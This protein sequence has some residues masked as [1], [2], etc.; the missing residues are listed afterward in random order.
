MVSIGEEIYLLAT[1]AAKHLNVSRSTFYIRYQHLLNRV[2]IGEGG[3]FYYAV[4]DLNK[5][6]TIKRFQ[7]KV[8]SLPIAS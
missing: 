4:S 3:W 2:K 7:A 6:Q 1:E 5:I 8:H